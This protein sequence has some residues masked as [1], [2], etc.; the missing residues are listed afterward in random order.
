MSAN[1]GCHASKKSS[2]VKVDL[3]ASEEAHQLNE[4]LYHLESRSSEYQS[5]VTWKQSS[6]SSRSAAVA[7]SLPEKIRID[8]FDELM[9]V[10]QSLVFKDESVWLQENASVKKTSVKRLEKKLQDE[11]GLR[12]SHQDFFA[13]LRGVPFYNNNAP[14]LQVNR[15]RGLFRLERKPLYI[16]LNEKGQVRRIIQN[17]QKDFR[18]KFWVDYSDFESHKHVFIPKKIHILVFTS[19]GDVKHNIHL[20]LSELKLPMNNISEEVFSIE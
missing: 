12:V 11:F 3:I 20:E 13:L 10:Y 18:P 8:F 5:F 2:Q 6:E 1:L 14:F 16:Q 4:Y 7:L 15:S 9:G 19:S 17:D